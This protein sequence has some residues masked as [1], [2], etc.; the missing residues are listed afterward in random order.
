MMPLGRGGGWMSNTAVVAETRRKTGWPRPSGGAGPVLPLAHGL[1]ERPTELA[2]HTCWPEAEISF[3][4]NLEL[5]FY[6]S[7]GFQTHFLMMEASLNHRVS[8]RAATGH[9]S[10]D[11]TIHHHSHQHWEQNLFN[12]QTYQHICMTITFHLHQGVILT[13]PLSHAR[14]RTNL[15]C[16]HVLGIIRGCTQHRVRQGGDLHV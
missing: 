1:G 4:Q 9:E 12:M 13:L 11:W 5:C 6:T 14:T 10:I 16:V 7:L 8:T 3:N 15:I 2:G